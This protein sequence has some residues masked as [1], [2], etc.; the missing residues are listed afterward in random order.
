MIVDTELRSRS[1]SGMTSVADSL[2]YGCITHVPMLV[3]YPSFVKTIHLGEAQAPGRLNLRDL[4]PRWVP[5]HGII[6]G[7]V[8][9]FALRNYILAHRPEVRQVGICQYRKFVT[10]DRV[11]QPGAPSHAIMDVITPQSATKDLLADSMPP[12]DH[13]FL[14]VK[15]TNLTLNGVVLPYLTQYMYAHHVEDL[16]RFIAM[17]VELGVLDKHDVVP[18]F[19]ETVF[20]LGGIELGVFPADFWLP[21]FGAIEEVTWAC[22]QRYDT[23]REGSQARAW[24]FCMERLGSYLLLKQ[25]RLLGGEAGVSA[26]YFG[27]LT[28][29]TKDGTYV[30]GI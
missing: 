29:I 12:K 17:A 2:C 11:G 3:E 19:D 27:Y 13:P 23:R 22:V 16:L 1:G 4:A 10:R 8:G 28:L 18:L 24:G 9:T 21:T 7:S 5:Y 30:P 14:L 20:L 15:P 26:N 6:G 25:L